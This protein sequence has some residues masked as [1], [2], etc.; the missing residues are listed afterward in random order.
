MMLLSVPDAVYPTA[1]SPVSV[2]VGTVSVAV[3]ASTAVTD[4]PSA[5]DRHTSAV[6]GFT[7]TW[8]YNQ[9]VLIQCCCKVW[10]GL[11]NLGL[12]PSWIYKSHSF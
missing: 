1:A 7:C 12:W 5:D 6:A 4:G 11:R 9:V 8:Q 2:A 3:S 10:V